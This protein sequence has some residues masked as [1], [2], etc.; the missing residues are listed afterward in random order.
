MLAVLPRVTYEFS[1]QTLLVAQLYTSHV[2]HS[3]KHTV[4]TINR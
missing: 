2:Y 4:I 3:G 1:L